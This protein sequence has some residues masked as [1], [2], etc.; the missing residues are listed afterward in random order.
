[1]LCLT[2]LILSALHLIEVHVHVGPYQSDNPT[3]SYPCVQQLVMVLVQVSAIQVHLISTPTPFSE[4]F[5]KQE[6]IYELF[7]FGNV[8]RCETYTLL[9]K[10][11]PSEYISSVLL[12]RFSNLD[13]IPPKF[14]DPSP[15]SPV[16]VSITGH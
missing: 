2:R 11:L 8:E 6:L 4:N 12:L 14:K 16:Q 13:R 7:H 10:F 9:T 15:A 3:T 1:M 5:I